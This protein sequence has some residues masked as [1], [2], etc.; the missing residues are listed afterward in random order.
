M[1]MLVNKRFF[2]SFLFFSF[3]V[4]GNNFAFTAAPEIVLNKVDPTVVKQFDPVNAI[5]DPALRITSIEDGAVIPDNYLYPVLEWQTPG[6]N[7]GVCLLELNSKYHRLQVYLRG[8]SWQPIGDQ[9]SRFLKD[10]Q[11]TMTVYQVQS[12]KT[13]RSKSIR[14]VIA[15]TPLPDHIVYRVVDP[16]FNVAK[17]NSIKMF[18]FEERRPIDLVELEDS[19]LGCHTYSPGVS[20]INV[21]K[22]KDRR[23]II[24]S[25][26][27][28]FLKQK[29]IGEFTFFTISP[30]GRYAAIVV[31]AIGKVD[32][33]PD[34]IEPFDLPYES[35]DIF[36]YDL[37]QNVLTPLNGASELDYIE[38]MPAFS[39]DGKW[40]IFARYQYEDNGIKSMDLYQVP[41]N[42]GHGG[43]AEPVKNAFHNGHY[44]YFPRFSPDGR[45]ISFCQGDGEKGI[46][47]RKSSDIYL[48]SRD[49]HKLRKLN[50][51]KDDDMDSW[52]YWSSDSHWLVI[53]SNREANQLTSLYLVYIDEQG[54][55]Y[56]P[57]KLIGYDKAKV[58]TPQFVP[59][60]I[61]LK[62][63]KNLKGFL[64]EE[65]KTPGGSHE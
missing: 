39:P 54:I 21:K 24:A 37:K 28:S 57:L 31:N 13:D 62:N 19:C 8:N 22:D 36:I 55:D 16:L 12:G 23:L 51:D 11:I 63:L 17:A 27:S 61:H 34:F 7:D 49:Q 44:N 30:N 6:N 14:V 60:N 2:I 29:I 58:N 38:D 47:A 9:F 65:F 59:G 56:P 50:F 4:L 40:L 48:L 15:P 45:W 46:F 20:L 43:T 35:G 25:N 64:D 18:S 1:K 52:H 42:G 33:K 32:I 5:V 41:F 10:H 26:D 53:S 3:G